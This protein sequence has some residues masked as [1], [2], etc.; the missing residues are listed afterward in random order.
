MQ[1][2]KWQ[3]P[4]SFIR[5]RKRQLSLGINRKR[6]LILF[7]AVTGVLLLIFAA[8]TLIGYSR[9]GFKEGFGL[10]WIY[11]IP[12]GVGLAIAYV[13]PWISSLTNAQI[14][15]SQTGIYRT[16]R[17]SAILVLQHWPWQNIRSWRISTVVLDE[18]SYRVLE[19]SLGDGQTISIGL[20]EKMNVDQLE[21][22]LQSI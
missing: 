13:I 2:I 14:A 5:A 7:L 19:F 21:D 8:A 3:E 9:H 20:S 6:Q 1:Q 15:V 16:S 11:V 12:F 10:W 4:A 18:A 22:L 17:E